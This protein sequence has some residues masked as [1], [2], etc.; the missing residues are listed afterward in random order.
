M[1]VHIPWYATTIRPYL[2]LLRM[3]AVYETQRGIVLLLSRGSIVLY[4]YNCDS[5][6][7]SKAGLAFMRI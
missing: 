5:L 7:E 2:I 4:P 1:P 3:C 6:A